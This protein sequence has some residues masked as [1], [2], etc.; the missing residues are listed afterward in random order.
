MSQEEINRFVT[1]LASSPE[2]LNHVKENASGLDSI[3]S[4]AK[5]H[6]YDVTLDEVKD[7]AQDQAARELTDADLE[8]LAGGKGDVATQV[9]VVQTADVA[10]T[11]AV[12]AEVE[13][14]G[15]AE[16]AG[17]A[18]VAAVAVIVLT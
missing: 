11:V 9:E 17:V 14:S 5:E 16:V 15:I 7:H 18:E 8:H 12:E 1:D 4:L 6:G 10:T 13:V 3:V 2:M